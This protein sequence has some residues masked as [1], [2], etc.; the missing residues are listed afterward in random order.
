MNRQIIQSHLKWIKEEM[1]PDHTGEPCLTATLEI[2]HPTDTLWFICQFVSDL[3]ISPLVPFGPLGPCG[4][5]D[6]IKIC[7]KKLVC[8]SV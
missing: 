1:S 2:F 4:Y 7:T 3:T 6:Y 5:K 8:F